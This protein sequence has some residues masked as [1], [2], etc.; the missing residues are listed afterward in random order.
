VGHMEALQKMNPSVLR[1]LE[2]YE[3]WRNIEL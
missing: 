1:K 3:G 2:E